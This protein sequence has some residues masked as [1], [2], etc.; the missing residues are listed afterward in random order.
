MKWVKWSKQ[1]PTKKG[2]YWICGYWPEGYY[3]C[4]GRPCKKEDGTF[5]PEALD[6]QDEPFIELLD[7]ERLAS[8]NTQIAFGWPKGNL[9]YCGP[10]PEP[11]L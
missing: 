7:E 11:N 2:W 1:D 5:E 6:E 10:I 3:D 8:I 9:V 4:D